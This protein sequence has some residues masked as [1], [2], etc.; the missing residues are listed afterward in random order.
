M[1]SLTVSLHLGPFLKFEYIWGW[2]IWKGAVNLPRSEYF[3]FGT[4]ISSIFLITCSMLTMQV[5][6]G[7]GGKNCCVQI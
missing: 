6:S 3:D 1:C 2:L 7:G 5:K 4:V